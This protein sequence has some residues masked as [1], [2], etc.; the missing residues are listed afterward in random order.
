MPTK[1]KQEHP[2]QENTLL[3]NALPGQPEPTQQACQ[4]C[5]LALAPIDTQNSG[6]FE[7][8]T[9]KCETC[10]ECYLYVRRGTASALVHLRDFL[11]KRGDEPDQRSLAD[12]KMAQKLTTAMLSDEWP[13]AATCVDFGLNSQEHYAAMQRAVKEGLTSYE[14]DRVLGD[15]KAITRL[16]AFACHEKDRC[17]IEF[18]TP[19]DALQD[20]PTWDDEPDTHRKLKTKLTLDL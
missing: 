4:F 11:E 20:E 7:S 18:S 1:D 12:C 13:S 17:T 2:N 14:L 3:D 5:V 9:L 6:E 19:Y 15:G 10:E 8:Q 16:V